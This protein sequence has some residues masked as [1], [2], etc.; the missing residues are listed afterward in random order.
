MRYFKTEGKYQGDHEIYDSREEFMN[1]EYGKNIKDIFI[2]NRESAERARKLEVGQWLESSDGYVV[3]VLNLT[4]LGSR[5]LVRVP[6]GTFSISFNKSG[7]KYSRLYAQFAQQ[8]LYSVSGINQ[9]HRTSAMR[10]RNI[11]FAE[12]LRNGM[13]VFQA[14]YFAEKGVQMKKNYSSTSQRLLMYLT[15]DEVRN[16]LQE[17]QTFIQTLTKDEDFSDEVMANYVKDFMDH[18]KKGSFVH[19]QSIPLLLTLLGKVTPEQLG[20]ATKQ[21][22]MKDVTEIEYETVSPPMIE[23]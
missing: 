15:S 6:M 16:V 7:V 13:T 1:S 18:V 3:Q 23:D 9:I 8:D 19:L 14:F 10:G 22:G 11:A 17:N 4:G 20:K 21:K 2:W 12:G 5:I